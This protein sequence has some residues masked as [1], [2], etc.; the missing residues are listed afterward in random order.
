MAREASRMAR[1]SASFV[2]LMMA[3]SACALWIRSSASHFSDSSRTCTAAIFAFCSARAA[4]A[5]QTVRLDLL[6]WLDLLVLRILLLQLVP[7][8]HLELLD[9][10]LVESHWVTESCR[11]SSS[12][13]LVPLS[14]EISRDPSG[15]AIVTMCLNVELCYRMA[16]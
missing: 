6:N 8:D 4:A 3:T 7:L 11:L 9:T 13:W 10:W 12:G 5:E 1:S 2:S 15:L 16:T 14:G